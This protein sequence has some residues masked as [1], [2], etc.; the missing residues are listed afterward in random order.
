MKQVI[1][2]RKKQLFKDD[3]TGDISLDLNDLDSPS[4]MSGALVTIDDDENPTPAQLFKQ[5]LERL[6]QAQA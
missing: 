2:P 6:Q 1:V 5:Q 3:I 4:G